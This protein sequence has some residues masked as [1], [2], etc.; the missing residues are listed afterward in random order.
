MLAELV[1]LISITPQE[2][3]KYLLSFIKNESDTIPLKIKAIIKSLFENTGTPVFPKREY[4]YDDY[5]EE[6]FNKK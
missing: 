6:I 4:E 1:D 5:M 2:Y 3:R